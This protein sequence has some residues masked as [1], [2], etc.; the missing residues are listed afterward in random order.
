MIRVLLADDSKFMQKSIQFM[1]Q[2]DPGVSVTGTASNGSEA[3]RMVGELDPDVIILDIE[4]PVMDG[5]STLSEIMENSPRPVLML[6]GLQG[7]NR[8]LAMLSLERGAVDFIRKPS[9]VI[10]YDIELLKSELIEKV[11]M[12]ADVTV[13]RIYPLEKSTA[14]ARRS[15]PKDIPFCIVIGAS[16]GG[17]RAITAILKDLPGSMNGAVIIV[18]HME[19]EFLISFANRLNNVASLPVSIAIDHE[20]LIPG[21]VYLAPGGKNLSLER[22]RNRIFIKISEP[23]PD[24]SGTPSIDRTMQSAAD[25]CGKSA[26]GVLLTGMGADGAEGL[27]AIQKK[28]GTTL[29][30]SESSCVIFGM[31]K[32]A[33]ESGFADIVVNLPAMAE[34]IMEII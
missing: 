27:G 32:A 34:T 7:Q 22:S 25:I 2:S 4:M 12:A 9:G 24:Q 23:E 14:I 10:S 6:T 15:R 20:E 5:L 31:P 18:Q 26:I 30:E 33:I 16:T 8:D 29:A 19:P 11:R 3:L 28:G 21:Q 17:P 13:H 1:L